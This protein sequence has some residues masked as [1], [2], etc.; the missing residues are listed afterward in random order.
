M[1]PRAKGWHRVRTRYQIARLDSEELVL[2]IINRKHVKTPCMP[3]PS[4]LAVQTPSSPILRVFAP[5]LL[6]QAL[7]S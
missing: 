6:A 5:S 2:G 4:S 3:E 7:P 1:G